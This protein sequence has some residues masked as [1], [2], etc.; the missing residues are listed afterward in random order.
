MLALNLRVS[1][2]SIAIVVRGAPTILQV[3][4]IPKIMFLGDLLIRSLF[5]LGFI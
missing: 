3:R 4:R 2:L 5:T 1:E